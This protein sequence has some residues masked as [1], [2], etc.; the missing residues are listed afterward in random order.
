MSIN[1][2]TLGRDQTLHLQPGE[3]VLTP[4]HQADIDLRIPATM[5]GPKRTEKA[6]GT[7]WVTDKRVIFVADSI[8]TPGTSSRAAAAPT[9]P[10]GYDSAPA[11]TSIEVPHTTL[12]SAT[13]NLPLLS[14][15]NI[16]LSFS[17]S[18]P[19][20]SQGPHITSLPDPGRGQSL[21][22][23]LIVGGGMGHAVWKRIEG[24]RT[25]A[26]EKRKEEDVLPA[27]APA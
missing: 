17:P 18:P 14:P 9:E 20:P 7:L 5:Q 2:V 10:P 26:E 22:L 25:R 6:K 11:L 12:K 21:E 13:Y 1:T 24:E 15:N 16:L 19:N 23:K 4:G 8:D 27:Y 3:E